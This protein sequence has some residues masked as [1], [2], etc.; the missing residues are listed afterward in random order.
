MRSPRLRLAGIL[1][2]VAVCLCAAL[3]VQRLTAVGPLVATVPVGMFPSAIAI[4]DVTEHALVL[5]A[6]DTTVS[7][8]DERTGA[9]LATRT[10]GSNGGA[11]PEQ[12]AVDAHT[13]HAFVLTD[14]GQVS[15]LDTRSGALLS[16][17]QMSGSP[18]A[19][20]IDEA[21][22]RAF[23]A[24]ADAGTVAVLDTRTGALLRTV[25]VGAFPETII[26][27]Q[28]AGM[29]LV[30]NQGDNSVSLLDA[31]TGHPM[32][33][34][35]VGDAPDAMAVSE[36]LREAY[37][38]GTHGSVAE[39]DAITGARRILHIHMQHPGNPI[40]PLVA[41]DDARGL[42]LI[43]IG[44]R[45]GERD[46]RTGNSE[47]MLQ[48][49]SAI[50][51]LA[52]DPRTGDVLATVRGKVDAAGHLLGDGSLLVIDPR[53]RRISTI[54]IGLNPTV[55]A[56]DPSNG[57]ALVADTNLNPDGTAVQSVPTPG[58]ALTVITHRLR[59]WLPGLPTGAAPP[60]NTGSVDVLRME[61]P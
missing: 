61:A 41:A 6:L 15:M 58:N 32:R 47:G 19:I 55:L 30:A 7:V 46:L 17:I 10:V 27:S 35:R 36:R 21:T 59:R 33:T 43:A 34:V 9:L 5:N 4:D 39:V 53:S 16:A 42:L 26:V 29:A 44:A 45:I 37:I 2:L 24:D 11:H 31:R 14:D 23:V 56:L 28:S 50:T 49:P 12:I 57:R 54:A 3:V 13:G 51:A 38:A 18:S 22:A 25:P 48:L 20:G 60:G 40:A 52:A 8:L 1:C